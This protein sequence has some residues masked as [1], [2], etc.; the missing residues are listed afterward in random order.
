MD[1]RRIFVFLLLASSTRIICMEDYYS[2]NLFFLGNS[3]VY[4]SRF[5]KLM[6][7]TANKMMALISAN[8]VRDGAADMSN[9]LNR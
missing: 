2:G 9:S 8:W 5:Q 7:H 4:G 6:K 1:S 3:Y